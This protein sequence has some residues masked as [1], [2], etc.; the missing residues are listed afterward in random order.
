MSTFNPEVACRVHDG[1][2]DDFI[3]WGPTWAASYRE[4]SSEQGAGIMLWDGALLD[5]W[6]VANH[7]HGRADQ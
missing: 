1:L 4:Y 2:N 3:D 7:P 6:L 5:G